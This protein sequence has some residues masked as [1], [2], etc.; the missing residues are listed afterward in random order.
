MTM[1]QGK[2]LLDVI[3]EIRYKRLLFIGSGLHKS[4]IYNTF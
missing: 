1:S 4:L 3:I 2:S